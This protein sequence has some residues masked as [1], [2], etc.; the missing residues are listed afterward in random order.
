MCMKNVNINTLFFEDDLSGIS[1]KTRYSEML[2]SITAKQNNINEYYIE[3]LYI[4]TKFNAMS[5]EKED[6]DLSK[7]YDLMWTFGCMI[8]ENTF[9]NT[10]LG[11]S[12]VDS[13]EDKVSNPFVSSRS[14]TNQNR[15]LALKNYKVNVPGTYYLKVY[16]REHNDH[17]DSE[18]Q[19]QSFNT[20]E[21][22][23]ET[24]K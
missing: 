5:S 4:Y 9:D 3:R 19:I 13:S 10:I 22:E 16:I 11:T 14:F 18:W 23:F 24:D 17:T 7:K 21:V 1:E 12:L 15:T 2:S 8:N 20:I 6:P